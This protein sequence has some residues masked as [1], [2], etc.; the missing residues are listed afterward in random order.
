MSLKRSSGIDLFRVAGVQIAVDFSWLIIFALV[1]WS[2]TAG[3]FPKLHPGY[4]WVEYFAVGLG[5]T[6]LFFG[7]VVIHELS[8]AMVANRLGQTVRRISLFIFGGMAHMDAEPASARDEL[9]IAGTGPLTS[10][11]LGALFWSAPHVFPLYPAWPMW[12]SVFEYLGVVNIA[13]AVFNLLPGFPL[14]GG[15][16]LRAALWARWDDFVRATAHA[17]NWGRG[18]AYGLIALGAIEIFFGTLMGGVWLIFIAFFLKRAAETSYQSVLTDQALGH[19]QVKQMMV[20]GPV[21]I[22]A[23]CTI[24]QA[25]DEYFL[26]RGY[27]GFP[28]MSDGRVAGLISLSDIR[29]CSAEE[30]ISGRVG[31]FMRQLTSAIRIAPDAT[32]ATALRQMSKEDAGRLLVMEREVLV[33]LIS[34]SAIMRFLFLHENSGLA[35]SLSGELHPGRFGATAD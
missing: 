3:Y 32:V 8:H 26:R 23:G 7:S 9:L 11:V 27:G 1:F 34:R 6:L 20:A 16:I 33:G 21:I 4:S 17:A 13:L 19:T 10:L 12:A 30:R 31:E 22:D 14:D 28:V 2:L 25:I 18:I 15:R 24:T 29:N 35:P 5:A